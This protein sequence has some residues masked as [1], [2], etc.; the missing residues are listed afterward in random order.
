M[1]KKALSFL[2]LLM[3]LA[4]A[5]VGCGTKKEPPPGM[6]PPID[7][8]DEV[9]D[10]SIPEQPLNDD[11]IASWVEYSRSLFLA[12]SRELDGTQYLLVTYGEKISGG[13]AALITNVDIQD[14]QVEVTVTFTEPAP[15]Q[16]VTDGIEYP[17]DLE[18]IPATGLPVVFI[19]EGAQEYVPQLLDLEYLLPMVA[20]SAGIKIFSPSPNAVV[21]RQF[22]VEGVANVYEGN[23]QYTLLEQDGTVLVRGF[24]TAAMGDWKAFTINLV[25]DETVTVEEPLLLKL[26]TESAKDGEIQDLIEIPLMLNE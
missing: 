23:I 21:E 16:E 25:V 5:A 17:Y 14:A 4:G 18:E 1:Q 20:E 19:A 26:Y 11:S 9:G 12:Q 8:E 2:L 6:E 13:Y 15:G 3:V 24:T 10:D 22:T 7:H